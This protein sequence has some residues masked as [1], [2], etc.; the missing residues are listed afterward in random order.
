MIIRL[1]SGFTGGE[2]EAIPGAI[3]QGEGVIHVV[4]PLGQ[5][6]ALGGV[7]LGAILQGQEE[8][9][10]EVILEATLQSQGEA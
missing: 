8:A 9:L 5:G 2:P 6:E 4:T 1:M 3:H 7:I 10:E